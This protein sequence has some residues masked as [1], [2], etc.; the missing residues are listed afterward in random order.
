MIK[1]DEGSHC[2]NWLASMSAFYSRTSG[3]LFVLDLLLK[4]DWCLTWNN[5]GCYV[6]A[7]HW[8]GHCFTKSLTNHFTSLQVLASIAST[9]TTAYSP[10]K[11]NACP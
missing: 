11:T 4:L 9:A 5:L 7:E 1:T 3:C 8:W 2:A 6:W 10:F